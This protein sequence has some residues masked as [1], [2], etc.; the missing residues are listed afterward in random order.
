MH[1]N[2]LL[3]AAALLFVIAAA[4]PPDVALTDEN[5]RSVQFYGDLVKGHVVAVNFIFTTCTTICQPMSGTFAKAETLLAGRPNARLVSITIDPETDTPERLAAWKKR[6]NG[7]ARWTMLTGPKDQ[8]DRLRKA[9]GV[10]TPDRINHTPTVVILDGPAGRTTRV[11]GLVS[12]R[13]IVSA[14]EGSR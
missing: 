13:A 4:P 14:M 5:G 10:F 7:G 3:I 9:L 8:I 11:I 1:R 12:A 2:R 6:F